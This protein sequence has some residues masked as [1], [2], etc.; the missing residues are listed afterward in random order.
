MNP[1]LLLIFFLFITTLS[2]IILII[3][4]NERAGRMDGVY[5]SAIHKMERGKELNKRERERLDAI[6][7]WERKNE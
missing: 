6:L 1:K 5:E 4:A 3:G 2:F 7:D